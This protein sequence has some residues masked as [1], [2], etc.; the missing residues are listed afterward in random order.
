MIEVDEE[1]KED[2]QETK[3]EASKEME[4]QR[5]PDVSCV[6][7]NLLRLVKCLEACGTAWESDRILENHV[8]LFPGEHNG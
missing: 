8:R 4:R 5:M 7:W 3:F 2:G 1:T 6:L